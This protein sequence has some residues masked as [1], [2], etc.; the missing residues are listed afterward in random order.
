MSNPKG[1]GGASF[2]REISRDVTKERPGACGKVTEELAARPRG[3]THPDHRRT[4]AAQG[5]PPPRA[6]RWSVGVTRLGLACIFGGGQGRTDERGAAV[7]A[8]LL[9]ELVKHLHVVGGH[10]QLDLDTGLGSGPWRA[11]K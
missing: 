3:L 10:A 9:L 4:L 11:R 1:S 5:N 8:K 6:V 7:E 2:P